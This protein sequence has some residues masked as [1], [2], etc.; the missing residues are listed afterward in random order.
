MDP[1]NFSMSV[2]TRR[3]LEFELHSFSIREVQTDITLPVTTDAVSATNR[4]IPAG[5]AMFDTNTLDKLLSEVG[6]IPD[7]QFP[8]LAGAEGV[9]A[10][11][12]DNA[13]IAAD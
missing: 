7:M 8:Q 10:K 9:I 12:L 4:D 13:A 2:R 3:R 11:G 6:Q 1:N 5:H